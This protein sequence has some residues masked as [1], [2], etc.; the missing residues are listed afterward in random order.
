VNGST[1]L[2]TG[3]LMPAKAAAAFLGV[4][5]TSLRSWALTGK[6]PFVRAPGERRMRFDRRDLERVIERWKERHGV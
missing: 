4:P 6:V 1:D 2:V 3:R 5:Y